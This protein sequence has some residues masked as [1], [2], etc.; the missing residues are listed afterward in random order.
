V[1][2]QQEIHRQAIRLLNDI[3]TV[4]DVL[5]AL[6]PDPSNGN[7]ALVHIHARLLRLA[8]RTKVGSP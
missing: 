6:D 2:E 1:S 4:I 5:R 8:T 3:E 7:N